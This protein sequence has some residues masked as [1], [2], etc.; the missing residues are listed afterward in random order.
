MEH[1]TQIIDQLRSKGLFREFLSG[2]VNKFYTKYFLTN[3]SPVS[4]K[5]RLSTYIEATQLTPDLLRID[6]LDYDIIKIFLNDVLMMTQKPIDLWL[7]LARII[8]GHDPSAIINEQFMDVSLKRSVKTYLIKRPVGDDYSLYFFILF[9]TEDLKDALI[10]DYVEEDMKLFS[11]A[12]EKAMLPLIQ[13]DKSLRELEMNN[14]REKS[15]VK[16]AKQALLEEQE[17]KDKEYE[18]RMVTTEFRKHKELAEFKKYKAVSKHQVIFN[19]IDRERQAEHAVVK[20]KV[21]PTGLGDDHIWLNI[22]HD[23][24]EHSEV[25]TKG[26]SKSKITHRIKRDVATHHYSINITSL[27]QLQAEVIRIANEELNTNPLFKMNLVFGYTLE[28][29]TEDG[30]YNYINVHPNPLRQLRAPMFIRKEHAEDNLQTFNNKI[31]DDLLHLYE[32]DYQTSSVKPVC[33]YKAILLVYLVSHLA[34]PIVIPEEIVNKNK[35]IDTYQDPE[36]N[37]C[38]WFAAYKFTT[39]DERKLEKMTNDVK[40]MCYKFCNPKATHIDRGLVSRFLR[41]YPGFDLMKDIQRYMDMYKHNVLIY[42]TLDN[43]TFKLVQRHIYSNDAPTMRLLM[44][45]GPLKANPKK[46]GTHM[47]LITNLDGLTGK[48][49]CSQCHNFFCTGKNAVREMENHMKNCKGVSSAKLQLQNH[50]KFYLPHILKNK[51][52]QYLVSHKHCDLMG[53][54]L[55]TGEIPFTVTQGYI[56]YDFETMEEYNDE[57]IAIDPKTRLP[58]K[59]TIDASTLKALSIAMTVRTESTKTFYYDLRNGDDFIE[60]FLDEL[61]KQALLVKKYNLQ[62]CVLYNFLSEQKDVAAIASIYKFF[63]NVKVL[64]YNSSKF[65]SHFLLRHLMTGN[66]SIKHTIGSASAM[67]SIKVLHKNYDNVSITFVDAMNYLGPGI[68]LKQF[69]KD[70]SPKGLQQESKGVFPYDLLNATNYKEVLGGNIIYPREVFYN[71]LKKEP[72]PEEEYNEYVTEHTEMVSEGE[73]MWD[74]LQKYNE[75]DTQIMIPALDNYIQ[76]VREFGIDLLQYIS[77]SS[78]AYSVK[79]AMCYQDFSIDGCYNV[80]MED[81]EYH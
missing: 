35:H 63:C 5:E 21:L 4:T 56:T 32:I 42:E 25:L 27:D 48:K 46:T 75:K 36:F 16:K 58:V 53:K 54:S 55:P 33:V 30:P 70:F 65:D 9:S 50:A 80:L 34:G 2:I 20:D 29:P 61:F 39:S 18:E 37:L 19:Y 57:S 3:D 71:S 11:K 62:T 40:T 43:K 73:C 60:Q 44:I 64:G 47:M 10:I 15:L 6:W 13:K 7:S 81:H 24:Q 17:R 66:C 31:Q 49:W 1:I 12:Q 76:M 14:L 77:L 8:N 26:L 74:Y 72:L 38:F 45:S 79:Y 28:Q 69:C 23:L 68:P 22:P 67:K 59:H 52:L 51:V 78:Y 41:E